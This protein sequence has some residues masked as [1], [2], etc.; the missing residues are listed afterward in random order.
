[1]SNFPSRT[2]ILL[3][4]PVRVDGAATFTSTATLTSGAVF[5]RG[6]AAN[7]TAD[8]TLEVSGVKLSVLARSELASKAFI[9]GSGIKVTNATSSLSASA[10]ANFVGTQ[11]FFASTAM[12]ADGTLISAGGISYLT[13]IVPMSGSATLFGTGGLVLTATVE[14]MS[15]TTNLTV[16][17]LPVLRLR[18]PT[19]DAVYTDDPF[20]ERFPVTKGVSL[21]IEGGAGRLVEYPSHTELKACDAFYLGGYQ[22]QITPAD[23]ALI[24]SAGFGDLIEEA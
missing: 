4:G 14:P 13:E 17:V 23:R 20:F 15:G 18:L 10:I 12:E 24:I 19:V 11:T 8:G 9:T 22:H 3:G 21:L 2:I 6:G 5:V 1:M 7:L 16:L